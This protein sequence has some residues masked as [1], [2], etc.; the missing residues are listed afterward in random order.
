M[1]LL[2]RFLA[3]LKANIPIQTRDVKANKQTM[4][5]IAGLPVEVKNK[6]V[7]DYLEVYNTVIDSKGKDTADELATRIAW[8]KVPQQFKQAAIEVKDDTK[9]TDKPPVKGT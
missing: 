4:S 7:K 5:R 8:C 1:A 2:D 3:D 9:A 6:W